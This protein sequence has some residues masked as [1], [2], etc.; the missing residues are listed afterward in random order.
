LI[1]SGAIADAK[2]ILCVMAWQMYQ[3]TGRVGIQG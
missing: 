1:A 3:M 2:T